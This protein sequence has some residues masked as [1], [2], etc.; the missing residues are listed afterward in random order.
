MHEGQQPFLPI[1]ATVLLRRGLH[2]QAQQL[3]MPQCLRHS[4]R[5]R[6]LDMQFLAMSQL[7]RSKQHHLG[8]P[9]RQHLYVSPLIEPLLPSDRRRSHRDSI[10]ETERR[11]RVDGLPM[12][13]APLPRHPQ[14]LA[15]AGLR[16]Q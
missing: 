1:I 12:L 7:S 15:R 3:P 16:Q 2:A 10:P 14:A 5:L 8:R 13:P 11:R 6:K 9:L 4:N